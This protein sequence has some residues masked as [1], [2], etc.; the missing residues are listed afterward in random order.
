MGQESASPLVVEDEQV[1]ETI[2]PGFELAALRAHPLFPAAIRAHAES[3]VGLH[4]RSRM[5]GWFLSDRTLAILAHAAVSLDA[6]VRDD[7]PR[8]GLTPGRFKAFCVRTGM[9]SEGRA[10]AILAF[11]RL[12]GHLEA[13]THPADRRITRLR[14]SAKLLATTRSRIRAQSAA[15]AMICPAVA[16]G[17]DRLDRPDFEREMYVEFLRRFTSARR[18]VDQVPELRLFTERDVGVLILYALMLGADPLEPFPTGK[19]VPLSIAALARQFNVSRTHVLRLIRDGERADLL[20]RVGEKG[21]QVALA[22]QLQEGLR[23]MSAAVFQIGAL[24]LR[25]A[26]SKTGAPGTA[27]TG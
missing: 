4:S 5:A 15:V 1:A 23:A 21:E 7:D 9:C 26:M 16:H 22:P 17:L 13:G 2:P 3:M 24:C 27:D 25:A 14:P 20:S 18:V 10:A 19:P 12:T 8:S 6:D 11:M